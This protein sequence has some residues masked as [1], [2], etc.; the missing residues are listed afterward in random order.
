[1]KLTKNVVVSVPMTPNFIS[2]NGV[3]LPIS[4]FTEKELREIGLVWTEE[5]I[6]KAKMR[7]TT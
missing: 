7:K 4:D 5:L 1:M 6:K 3:M 2:V